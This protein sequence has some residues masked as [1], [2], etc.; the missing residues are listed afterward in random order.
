MSYLKERTGI[1]IKEFLSCPWVIV[2]FAT[3]VLFKIWSNISMGASLVTALRT[4]ILGALFYLAGC[5]AISLLAV[6]N[7]KIKESNLSISNKRSKTMIVIV[8]AYSAIIFT[9]TYDFVLRRINGNGLLSFIPGYDVIL[10]FINEKIAVPLSEM[11]EPYSRAYIFSSATGV[12]LYIVIPL[13]LFS[14]LNFKLW[15]VFNLMNTRANWVFVAGYLIVFTINRPEGSI[16]WMI[17]ATLIYPALAEEF[18]HKAVVLRSVNNIAK[19]VGTAVVVSALI[20]ALMHFPER[21]LISFDGNILQTFS[22]IMTVGLFGV[23]TGYGFVK[24]GT[25]IPWVIIH[26]LSNIISIA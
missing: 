24:T 4:G 22:K 12:L 3:F 25:I 9:F 8:L 17:L 20:F 6:D 19:K 5:Y 2:F 10:G 26:A 7:E 1:L 18:F 23:F 16:L 14:L 13:I 11:V 15:K 21:Y